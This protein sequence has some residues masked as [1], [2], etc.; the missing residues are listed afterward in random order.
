M[1]LGL[2]FYTSK[3]EHQETEFTGS[4]VR[5]GIGTLP[6]QSDVWRHWVHHSTY[7][8]Q[9]RCTINLDIVKQESPHVHR[10]LA[11]NNVSSQ[12]WDF[13]WI[14]TLGLVS[15]AVSLH[16]SHVIPDGIIWGP[17]EIIHPVVIL[18]PYSSSTDATQD[19]I[20]YFS[21]VPSFRI[22]KG[23]LRFVNDIFMISKAKSETNET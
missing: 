13:S 3:K 17:S 11:V 23:M 15:F 22:L 9:S 20:M 21:L 10:I 19:Q 1:V 12:S 2:E 7:P 16:S 18:V 14:L 6:G 4:Q 5:C 8:F